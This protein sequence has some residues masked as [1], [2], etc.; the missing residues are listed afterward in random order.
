MCEYFYGHARKVCCFSSY[1]IMIRLFGDPEHSRALPS[2]SNIIYKAESVALL[3]V[4]LDVSE[5]RRSRLLDTRGVRVYRMRHITGACGLK[6]HVLFAN[7]QSN[8]TCLLRH[9]ICFRKYWYYT[10][11][12]HLA[13]GS[14]K[15]SRFG[16]VLWQENNILSTDSYAP[17]EHRSLSVI[18]KRFGVQCDVCVLNN[19]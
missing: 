10:I 1:S 4:S 19:W 3:N 11:R 16:D 8:S 17:Q 2:V 6:S 14:M 12:T 15:Q 13:N 5:D 9:S 18:S 7:I